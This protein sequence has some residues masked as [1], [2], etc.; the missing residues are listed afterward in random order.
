MNSNHRVM[1][2][3]QGYQKIRYEHDILTISF[4]NQFNDVFHS[5]QIIRKLSKDWKNSV[6][7]HKSKDYTSF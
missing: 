7:Y 4:C 5:L 2:K 6:K 3:F 1:L